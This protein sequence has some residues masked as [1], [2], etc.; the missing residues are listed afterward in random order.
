MGNM[1]ASD[2]APL[3]RLG[4][5]FFDVRGESRS[6]RLS[7]YADTGVAVFSIWQGG[8]CTGT[9]RLPIADLPR[10]VEALRRGPQGHGH[11]GLAGQPAGDPRGEGRQSLPA[12]AGGDS[13]AGQATA[14]LHV[15]P[16]PLGEPGPAGGRHSARRLSDEYGTQ[17]LPG[18]APPEGDYPTALAGAL[19]AA[20]GP[21]YEDGGPVADYHTS[22]PADYHTSPPAGYDS[23]PLGGGYRG[24]RPAAYHT[25]PQPG[26][27]SGPE[28]AY[29]TGSR[30][31]YQA[32]L[33]GDYHTDP[34][35]GYHS[36]PPAD[37]HGGSPAGYGTEPH[38]GFPGQPETRP[39]RY[40]AGEDEPGY[41]GYPAEGE[42]GYPGFRHAGQEPDHPGVP[43]A[44]GGYPDA[45]P[46]RQRAPES[47][48]RP[49][50]AA[51]EPVPADPFGERSGQHR[52]RSPDEHDEP[53]PES[54]PYGAPPRA[55]QPHPR[56]GYTARD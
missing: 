44:R 47:P 53:S 16:G 46:P 38:R 4:E 22:P 29:R 14:A 51:T 10:M 41:G 6:M 32:E 18:G 15:P 3:P 56:E 50:V 31:G 12:P 21:G 30:A 35:A 48:A 54:F 55:R 17:H 23:G 2:A 43:P 36:G 42:Q 1:S 37:Y 8:T 26:Y 34:P 20:P 45:R 28:A 24:G 5:V 7:W 25:G 13:D 9:F 19:P 27:H 52:R 11:P 49:Y 40:L 33:P 39:G